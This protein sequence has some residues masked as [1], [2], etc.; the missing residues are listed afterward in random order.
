MLSY[1]KNVL[2]STNPK[3]IRKVYL[4]K[5]KKD[6]EV[7][8][9][10][11]NNQIHYINVDNQM[12]NKM[13]KENHQGIVFERDDFQYQ[14][15]E[16]LYDKSFIV[17]LD[18]L[19]DPHNFG[20]IIRTCEA[21]GVDGIIIPKDRS[22]SVTDV[23]IKTSVGTTENVPIIKVSNLTDAIKKLQ[24]NNFFVY[25]SDMDGKD[26][27]EVSYA[28]KKVL[29]IG[30]EGKGISPIIEKNCDEMLK[31]AMKGKVNSLNASV[32]AALLIYKM[33]GLI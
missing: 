7:F 9:Y 14:S 29:V 33:G 3:E 15:L 13:T 2:L 8:E 20:A 1:G 28:D 17:L 5:S 23:V 12:L 21:A 32:A 25:G 4:S 24:K 19:E 11:K 26:C 22:V 10:L 16:N 31:I 30:N 27:R 18:H 6:A